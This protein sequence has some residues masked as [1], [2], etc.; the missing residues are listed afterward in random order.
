MKT[1]IEILV[2]NKKLTDGKNVYGLDGVIL[3][4][5]RTNKK[6]TFHLD[7]INS[8]ELDVYQPTEAELEVE[9]LQGVIEKQRET[10]VKLKKGGK[11]PG[12]TLEKSSKSKKPNAKKPNAKKAVGKKRKRIKFTDAQ[13]AKF[14]KLVDEGMSTKDLAKEFNVEYYTA[15]HKRVAR[16]KSLGETESSTPATS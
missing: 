6:S 7:T 11:V 2:E 5:T 12:K 15:Y 14:N 8:K 9:R 1:N 3:M 4:N 16:L 13:Q 10:I